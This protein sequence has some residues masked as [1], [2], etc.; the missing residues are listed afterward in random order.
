M[1]STKR[2]KWGWIILAM[3]LVL[4]AGGAV[5]YR[6]A[7]GI[8]KGKVVEA[9]G[10]GS[11]I[12][13]IQVGWSGVAVRGLRIKGPQGWPAQDALR[14]ERVTIVPSL[15][16]LLSGE[17]RV[18][19]VTIEKPYLSALRAKDGKLRV[20]P[21]L[22]ERPLAKGGGAAPPAAAPPAH[23]ATITLR[24]G[25]V[26]F[27]DATVAQP[28][29]KV[30]LEQLQASLRNVVVPALTGKSDFDLTGVLKGVRQDGRIK[31]G[32]WAEAATR[33]STVKTELRGVDLVALQPYLSKAAEVRVQEG[34]LDLDIQSDVRKNRLR[35]PGRITI[36][37]LELAPSQGMMGTFMGVPRGA[38]LAFLKDKGNQI[39]MDFII[40]GDINNPQF[41]LNEAFSTRMAASMAKT[42]GVSIQG[43]AE[44]VGMLG[45]KGAEAMGGT[46]KG[47]GNAIGGLFGVQKK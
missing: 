25:V 42:L 22:L 4:V 41:S 30:R 1:P 7:V 18:R 19:S 13:D 11:E 29:L 2:K 38:V 43:V 23:I 47:I 37:G 39:A 3:L 44:G 31:I 27:F 24:D 46:A 17:I 5:G 15:L 35:A 40:E 36:A 14:A 33:D 26:E 8:L 9:L 21:T 20:V 32:G 6:I 28:P 45:R 10:P 12:Q 16:D 34:T